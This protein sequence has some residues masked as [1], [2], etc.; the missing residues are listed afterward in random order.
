VDE[1]TIWELFFCA[2]A[3]NE[4]AGAG[5]VAPPTDEEFDDMVARHALI[6]NPHWR[7]EGAKNG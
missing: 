4:A 1:L 5:A 6:V 2:Q 3:N 7:K